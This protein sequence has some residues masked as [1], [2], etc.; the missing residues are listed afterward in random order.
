M[1]PTLAIFGAEVR[2]GDSL[3]AARDTLLQTIEG[4]TSTPPTKEEV[5][6][7]RSQILKNIELA[8]NNSDQVGAHTK[9]VYWRRRL[10]FVFL[11]RD[12]LRKVTPEEV[13]AG[14]GALFQA[15]ESHAGNVY[16]HGQT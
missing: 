16:P 6:R 4:I 10:A 7:A 11:H 15:V 5:E 8:L 3:D 1:I 2:Q 9:R 12:R 14:G 13:T